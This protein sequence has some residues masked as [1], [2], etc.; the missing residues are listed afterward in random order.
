VLVR[1]I[2]TPL[3]PDLA[4]AEIEVVPA[5]SSHVGI[6]RRVCEKLR[7]RRKSLL[8]GLN[9]GDVPLVVL[10][11]MLLLLLLLHAEPE[12]IAFTETRDVREIL[13][14]LRRQKNKIIHTH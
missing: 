14:R 2:R 8:D 10:G 9:T 5:Y 13:S 11:Q 1:S 6:K 3:C 4:I 12:V 7:Y